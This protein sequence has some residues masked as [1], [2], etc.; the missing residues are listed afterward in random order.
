MSIVIILENNQSIVVILAPSH[1]FLGSPVFEM[2]VWRQKDRYKVEYIYVYEYNA[3]R[4]I[5]DADSSVQAI[6]Q[7]FLKL[8]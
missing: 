2:I 3:T 4:R 1:G 5:S 7:H 8:Y 6:N